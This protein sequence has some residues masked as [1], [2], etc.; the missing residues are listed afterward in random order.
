LEILVEEIFEKV[1]SNK[2]EGLSFVEWCEW[3]TTLDGV[4]EMLKGPS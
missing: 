4:N 1:D 2:D 3:F